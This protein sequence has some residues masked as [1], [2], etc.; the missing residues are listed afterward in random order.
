MRFIMLGV[1]YEDTPMNELNKIFLSDTNMMEI[2]LKLQDIQIEQSVILSTCNRKEI[3]Y[4]DEDNHIEEVKDILQHYMKDIPLIIRTD[5]DAYQ[6][7][8]AVTSGLHSMV[9]GEDQILG[10]VVEA[11]EFSKRCGCLKKRNG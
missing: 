6:Y 7:L 8:F 5:Q 2:Y 4:M 10:Q 9:L 1:S 3:Y 11:M